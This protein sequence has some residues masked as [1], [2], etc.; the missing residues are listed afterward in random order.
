MF[1][2]TGNAERSR[3][4]VWAGVRSKEIPHDGDHGLCISLVLKLLGHLADVAELSG[5][6]RSTSFH[7]ILALRFNFH[8]SGSYKANWRTTSVIAWVNLTTFLIQLV[9]AGTDGHCPLTLNISWWIIIL[10]LFLRLWQLSA[11]VARILQEAF[12]NLWEF[13]KLSASSG[14]MLW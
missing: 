13:L 7:S 9:L 10:I 11:N 2:W 14:I 8:C 3:Y 1:E 12:S 4:A 5:M 6:G